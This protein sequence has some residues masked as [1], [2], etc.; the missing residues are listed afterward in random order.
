MKL[1]VNQLFWMIFSMEIVMTS[2]LTIGPAIK[3][4]KQGAWFSM[5]VAV[6]GAMLITYIATKISLLYPNQTLI[7]FVPYI[8]GKWLGKLISLS[9]LLVWY[10]VAGVILREFSDFVHQALFTSTPMWV[11]TL[12]MVIAMIYAVSGEGISIIGRCG[13]IIGPFILINS[14]IMTVLAIKDMDPIRLLP[15]IPSSGVI[16]IWKGSLGSLSFMGESI[17][18]MML[19][20]F[21]PD[22]RKVFL[23]T[24]GGVAVSGLLAI[25][26]TMNVI[27]VLGNKLPA[28]LQYPVY[29]LVQ[30]TSVM[31]FIQNI[32]V[33][34]VIVS[35]FSIFIKLSLYL[36][37]TSYGTSQLLNFK[38]SNSMV[39]GSA[40]VIFLIAFLPRNSNV[41]IW[42]PQFW[43]S[44][45]FPIFIVGFPIIL[46][47][48]SLVRCRF[49]KKSI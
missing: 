35:N 49:Q 7:E 45:I 5:V 20:A 30:Y 17:M 27:M 13:E 10:T 31:E 34:G 48:V 1:T 18:I 38:K 46:L 9:Y 15:I 12:L 8:V 3:D 11:I 6:I 39:W 28:K 41:L 16:S 33:L 29:T 36:F 43:K 21:L 14:V 26:A 2:L 42:F 22:K 32:D 25:N 37:I 23:S 19:I 47:V 44:V 4:A 40:L 24:I